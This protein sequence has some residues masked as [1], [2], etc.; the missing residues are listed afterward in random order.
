MV[1]LRMTDISLALYSLQSLTQIQSIHIIPDKI[2]FTEKGFR[3]Q[4]TGMDV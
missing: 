4:L 2:S 3:G 1:I